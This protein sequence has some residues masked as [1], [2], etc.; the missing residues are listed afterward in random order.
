MMDRMHTVT[1]VMYGMGIDAV[2]GVGPSRLENWE[3][4]RLRVVEMPLKRRHAARWVFM[5]AA[6][7]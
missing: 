6:Q 7:C 2:N 4:L 5:A 1:S 3:K